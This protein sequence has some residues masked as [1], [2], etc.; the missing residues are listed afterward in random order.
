MFAVCLRYSGNRSEAEDNL[1]DGFIRV[2][3]KIGGFAY[4]GA[5]EGWMRRIVINVCL[6][7]FRDQQTL[8]FVE[9]KMAY[10]DEWIEEAEVSQLSEKRL[11]QFICE[12]PPRYRMV[13]N[14]Y[15]I[16]GL[17]HKEIAQKMGISEGTSKS[18]LARARDIMRKKVKQDMVGELKSV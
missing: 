3:D 12:L 8:L 1:H 16:D 14:L 18:N 5:F 2:F 10:T 13:F 9:E 6:A 4:K 11:L 7:K 15:V 17:S